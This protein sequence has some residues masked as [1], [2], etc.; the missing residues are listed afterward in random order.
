MPSQM[1]E[2]PICIHIHMYIDTRMHTMPLCHDSDAKE[3]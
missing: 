2:I 3:I 1:I